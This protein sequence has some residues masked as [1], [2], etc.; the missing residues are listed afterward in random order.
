MV[1]IQVIAGFLLIARLI[2]VVFIGMVLVLQAKLFGTNID[3]TLVPNLS[4]FQ[5]RN[6]YLARK[7]LFALAIIVFLGNMIPI[8]I[9][10]IT[11]FNDNSLG[12]NPEVPTISIAYA[13][14]NALT[15]MFSA[16]F[17][18]VLYKLAGLG[19]DNSNHK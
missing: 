8:I 19:G 1:S 15:A 17:I 3:F 13:A 18:W 2:S 9:D 10:A 4:K 6:I 5:K 7:V 16:I 11:A 14:G 12:R